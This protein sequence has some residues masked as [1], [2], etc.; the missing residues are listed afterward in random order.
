[1]KKTISILLIMV[2]MLFTVGCNL[3]QSPSK[4]VELEQY[5]SM[6]TDG[7]ISI[8]VVYDYIRGE[9]ATYEFDI[10]DQETIEEIMTE[11]FNMELKDYP[12]DQDIQFYQ[13][14]ITVN[15]GN[16]EYYVNLAYTSDE[17]GNRYLCQSQ[18]VCEIIEEYIEDNL[19]VQSNVFIKGIDKATKIEVT[20]FDVGKE[21]G[22][23]T[24]TEETSVK[25]IVDNLNSLEL[26]KMEYNMPTA[27]E[28]E[29]VFYDADGEM[30]KT[31]SITLDGWVDY[32]GSFHS[33]I[34]G[35]LDIAYLD[36]LFTVPDEDQNQDDFNDIFQS[37]YS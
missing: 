27:I 28:Y 23:V 11:V 22:A 12:E 14:W 29:L 6:T 10:Y 3:E 13:R 4:L 18:K 35:E 15:Q 31:I 37:L 30:T 16:N 26:E 7:T 36:G 34:S 20:K 24:V 2:L 19:T 5:S 33:V 1:M 25:H 8:E 9:E 21:V 17:N 32:H